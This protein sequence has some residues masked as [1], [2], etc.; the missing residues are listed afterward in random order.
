[1]HCPR[2]GLCL[3]LIFILGMPVAHA[4]SAAASPEAVIALHTT[5]DAGQTLKAE[6]NGTA[7]TFLFDSG[8]GVSAITPAVAAKIG[9]KP[10]GQVTGFR[11]IG[12]RVD[13]K[14][15]NDGQFKIGSITLQAPTLAVIDLMKFIPDSPVK[16][17]GAIGLDTFAGKQITIRSRTQQLIVESQASLA[18]RIEHAHAVPIRLV[19]DSS[20]AALTVNVGVPT[21][22]GVVWMELDTGNRSGTHLVGKHI[23]ELLGLKPDA[24]G[25]QPLNVSIVPGVQLT[26]DAVVSDL[27]MDGNI[28]SQF[29]DAWDLTL[30][31]KAEKGWLAPAKP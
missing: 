29:L 21:K 8:W 1:M 9:C 2:Y 17:A 5:K 28:G 23:A 19:R 30:D 3:G 16:F 15:C 22:A 26:G 18:A 13:M 24:P 27:I 31:L 7:G 10:W 14:K 12:E 4:L 25:K 20:G 6:V 11:A